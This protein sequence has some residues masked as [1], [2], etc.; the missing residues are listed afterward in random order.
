M[1]LLTTLLLAHLFADFPL[2]TNGLAKLKKKSLTGVFLHVLVYVFITA[3]AIQE[4]LTY[5]PLIV[6]LGVAHFVIDALKIRLPKTVET[7]YFVIDQ[8]LHFLSIAVA[9]V[10]AL[11][12]WPTPPQSVLPNSMAT[13]ALGC[14][15]VLAVMVFCWVWVNNLNEE[16]VQR[17]GLLRWIK[18]QMLALEQRIGLI[19]VGFVFAGPLYQWLTNIFHFVAK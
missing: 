3:W 11:H 4:P 17:N 19:L 14:A 5:W 18:E 7:F 10:I 16:E 12:V 13:V 1:Q 2:Q 15:L 6:G 8:C 9:T